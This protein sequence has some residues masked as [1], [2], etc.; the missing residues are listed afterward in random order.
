MTPAAMDAAA[1][2]GAS[3]VVN[4]LAQHGADLNA[5]AP[6]N[7]MKIEWIDLER[8]GLRCA[9]RGVYFVWILIGPR[10]IRNFLIHTYSLVRTSYPFPHF[11]LA[12]LLALSPCQDGFVTAMFP[13]N[14]VVLKKAQS[15]TCACFGRLRFSLCKIILPTYRTYRVASVSLE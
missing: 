6:M 1:G 13:V 4:Q 7:W 8:S 9:T 11:C 2:S 15:C 5:A 10:N 3:A 14:P 12:V